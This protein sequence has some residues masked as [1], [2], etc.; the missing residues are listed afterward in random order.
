VVALAG[1]DVDGR[2]QDESPLVFL[3]R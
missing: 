3:V 2:F 1:E